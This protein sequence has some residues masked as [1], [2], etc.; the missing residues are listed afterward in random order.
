MGN[1]KDISLSLVRTIKAAPEKVFDAWITPETLKRWMAPRDD[2][3]VVVAETDARIGG[4][5]RLVMREP[6]GKEHGVSGVYK[7]IDRGRR[8]AFTWGWVTTPEMETLVT[9]DFREVAA[10]TELTLTHVKFAAE[11]VRDMHLAGWNG[12]VG[13]LESLFAA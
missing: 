8:L 10:G 3:E 7:E 11:N 1:T 6:D 9:L 12:C 2:M 13:R 4:R 5:Y